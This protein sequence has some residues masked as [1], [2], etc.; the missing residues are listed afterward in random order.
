MASTAQTILFATAMI[1]LAM[2]AHARGT[3]S[4][5]PQNLPLQKGE[6][7]Q[8][9]FAAPVAPDFQGPPISG[10]RVTTP[11]DTKAPAAGIAVEGLPVNGKKLARTLK[12]FL[13]KPLS[14]QVLTDITRAIVL[15]YK[16]HS[17]MLVDVI[18]P[19]GQDIT[20]GRV[21][22]VVVEAKLGE[23]SNSGNLHF[24]NE[25]VTSAFTT[26]PGDS[27]NMDTMMEDLDWAN[28]NPFRRTNLLYRTG[29]NPGETDVVLQTTDRRP[30]R[31]YAGVNNTGTQLT[32]NTRLFAGFNVGDLW[33]C[34]HQ[35]SY[36]FTTSDDFEK[37]RGHAVRYTAPLPWRHLLTL[38]AAHQQ[39]NPDVAL[40]MK[41][42]GY[43]YELGA[44]YTIPLRATM[45]ASHDFTLGYDFKR[46]DNNLEFGGVNVFNTT[47]DVSQFSGTYTMKGEDR[48]GD[49]QFSTGLVFSPGGA[50]N[51]NSDRAHNI[52]RAGASADYLYAVATLQRTTL[53]PASFSLVTEAELQLSSD[54]LPGSEQLTLGGTNSVRGYKEAENSGDNGFLFRNELRAPSFGIIGDDAFTV[55]AFADYGTVTR[56]SPIA[57]TETRRDTQLS[58]GP[59]LRYRLGSNLDMRADYGF[60]LRSEQGGNAQRAHVGMTVSY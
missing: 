4:L 39:V 38:S 16:K 35:L 59:G 8:Q 13:G 56:N 22:F 26:K 46:A 43:S 24:S 5:Q 52:A 41:S 2:A 29:A 53:L 15:H 60:Q 33:C 47:V 42:D 51:N 18:A 14:Q 55:L 50:T 1:P 30:Y 7:V 28:R 40:P 20:E 34:G 49:T 12:P 58:V 54:R 19:A 3:E 21:R 44:D 27:I 48:L 9:G 37:M 45:S 10:L 31:V 11:A 32:G 6:V 25:S 36:Q 57:G 17:G 23:L